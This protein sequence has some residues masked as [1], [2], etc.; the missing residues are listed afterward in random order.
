MSQ[1]WLLRGLVF[2]WCAVA[3]FCGLDEHSI[4]I[5][6]LPPII[7]TAFVGAA[8]TPVWSRSELGIAGILVPNIADTDIFFPEFESPA[9]V[10]PSL[11]SG[12]GFLNC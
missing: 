1:G 5:I 4:I 9:V 7:G 6:P 8:L 3:F 10:V 12:L 11:E 2:L